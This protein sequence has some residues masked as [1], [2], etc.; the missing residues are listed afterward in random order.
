MR[1]LFQ[2]TVCRSVMF[3]ASVATG[4]G[5]DQ[6]TSTTPAGGPIP[7]PPP[8]TQNLPDPTNDSGPPAT[9]LPTLPPAA[10]PKKTAGEIAAELL[11][12]AQPG[13]PPDI[14][15]GDVV[16]RMLEC[17]QTA[18]GITI[19]LAI[20]NVGE[21]LETAIRVGELMDEGQARY[22]PSMVTFNG[23]VI[24]ADA[25]PVTLVPSTPVLLQAVWISPR[26]QVIS[27][28]KQLPVLLS[29]AEQPA[30]FMNPPVGNP[31]AEPMTSERRDAAVAL[32]LERCSASFPGSAYWQK[33]QTTGRI[34][35]Q[36]DGISPVSGTV[37]GEFFIPDD[38]QARKA[39]RLELQ[40]DAQSGE[41]QGTLETLAGSG[42]RG[43]PT[44]QPS[45]RN[46]LLHDS[47]AHYALRL[48]G[49]E[50]YGESADGFRLSITAIPPEAGLRL[51]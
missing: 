11:P 50:L 5:C 6:L 13:L 47:T 22:P 18:A 28:V 15:R 2:P 44:R 4:S 27:G 8:T 1:H 35:V 49:H 38:R 40:R 24:G 34:A 12:P 42:L 10:P 46:L 45:T 17:Y 32:L 51:E 48:Y 9:V 29:H 25:L 31:P 7:S 20:V 41:L 19:T 37:T 36:L 23:A 26:T 33:N 16:L 14:V 21:E 30:I 43:Q 3:L 39:F